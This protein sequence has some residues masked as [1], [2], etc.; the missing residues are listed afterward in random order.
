[1]NNQTE[2]AAFAP[3]VYPAM[4]ALV[5][6]QKCFL[7]AAR[8]QAHAYQAMMRYQIE[9]LAFLKHRCEQDVKLA[10]DF[11]ASEEF[12]DALHVVSNFVEN[13]TSDYAAEM[14]KVASIGSKLASETAQRIRKEAQ[15]TI[16]D[17]AA[18]TLA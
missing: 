7:A 4:P 18:K 3:P 9:A 14:S 17:K 11:A 6:G 16:E 8:L 10:E 1:M 2:I 15:S 5:N 12:N 13:A